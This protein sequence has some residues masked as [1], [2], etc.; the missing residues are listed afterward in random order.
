MLIGQVSSTHN[1]EVNPLLV[2]SNIARLR[3]YT[4]LSSILSARTYKHSARDPSVD[5]IHSYQ[6]ES[7]IVI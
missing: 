7:Y 3:C 4:M 5:G 6:Y 1:C 2:N